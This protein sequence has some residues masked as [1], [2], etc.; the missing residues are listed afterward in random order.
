[1]ASPN[2]RGR[3]AVTLKAQS[4]KLK[5]SA[6]IA[7]LASMVVLLSCNESGVDLDCN[8]HPTAAR[9]WT[10]PDGHLTATE[11]RTVCPGWYALE[12]SI[13]DREG[14]HTA[15]TDRPA[16]Q[17]RPPLWPDLKVEW[18]SNQEM[19]ISYGAG[20]DTTCIGKAGGV[21]VHCLDTVL[22]K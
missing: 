7:V 2:S 8:L 17:T 3:T 13:P 22:S 20:Q 6:L 21:E 1:M 4:S 12:I 19:W 14:K 9:Q 11:F 16:A 18:K 10:S 15:F 5:A